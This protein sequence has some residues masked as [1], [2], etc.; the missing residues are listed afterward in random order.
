MFNRLRQKLICILLYQ[1][2]K[3]DIDTLQSTES[4]MLY[5]LY[6]DVQFFVYPLRKHKNDT[7]A[8]W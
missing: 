5:S 7:M 4:S 8:E 1:D 3:N 2:M 6:K